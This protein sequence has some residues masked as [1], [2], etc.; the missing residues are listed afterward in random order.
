[1]RLSI[2]KVRI[3]PVCFWV[4]LARSAFVASVAFIVQDSSVHVPITVGTV[5]QDL[6]RP[7][8]VWQ[9]I[10]GWEQ[11]SAQKR[12]L[13]EVRSQTQRPHGSKGSI[14]RPR[15]MANLTTYKIT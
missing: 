4:C 3:F 13:M 1:M 8:G 7:G 2:C 5:I 9:N 10:T 12:T 11:W 14:Q 15:G 6:V